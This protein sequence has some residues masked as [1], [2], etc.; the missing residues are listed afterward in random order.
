MDLGALLSL[1]PDQR[2][3]RIHYP[4][5]VILPPGGMGAVEAETLEKNDKCALLDL[6]K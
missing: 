6:L 3:T 2:K 5:G 4:P 1:G